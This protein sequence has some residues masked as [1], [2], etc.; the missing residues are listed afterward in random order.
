MKRVILQN[1][2]INDTFALDI[3]LEALSRPVMLLKQLP[4]RIVGLIAQ[5]S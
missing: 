2:P 5:V 3:R 1:I 4:G